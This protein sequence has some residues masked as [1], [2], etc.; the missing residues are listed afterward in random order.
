VRQLVKEG[1]TS[2]LEGFVSKAG[3]QFAARLKMGSGGKVEFDF[4]DHGSHPGTPEQ[5]TAVA[6]APQENPRASAP[7]QWPACPKCGQ[8]RIIQGRR[9]Y[10]CNRYRE[11]CD[12][13]VWQEVSGKKLT[14]N[15]VHTLIEKGKTRLIHGFSS[16]TGEKFAARLQLDDEGRTVVMMSEPS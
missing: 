9:G 2:R 5:R 1:S 6:R 8:G 13:V 10:G 4:G 3:K 16:R 14:V 12:F 11:G 7:L 15:Q